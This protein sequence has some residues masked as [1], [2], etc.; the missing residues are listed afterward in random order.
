MGKDDK[1]HKTHQCDGKAVT[2]KKLRPGLA[3]KHN[4]RN[5]RIH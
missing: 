2:M 3:D 4:P 1:A 5:D